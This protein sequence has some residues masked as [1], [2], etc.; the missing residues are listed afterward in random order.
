[1]AKAARKNTPPGASGNLAL[2]EDSDVASVS[3][4]VAYYANDSIRKALK[5]EWLRASRRKHVQE[6]DWQAAWEALEL[7][8]CVYEE[9]TG[10]PESPAPSEIRAAQ[11]DV[12]ATLDRLWRLLQDPRPFDYSLRAKSAVAISGGE[13]EWLRPAL[14]QLGE[15]RDKVQTE[16]RELQDSFMGSRLTQATRREDYRRDFLEAVFCVAERIFDQRSGSADGP[17]VE[18]IS[19][20]ARRVLGDCTPAHD[21]IRKTLQRRL[22]E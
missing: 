16:V 2:S 5:Q 12:L 22:K 20:A 14:T 13:P 18:F 4:T 9:A 1:V 6:P 15:L 3:G 7:A 19:L 10:L 17:F 11:Y 21:A 8:A